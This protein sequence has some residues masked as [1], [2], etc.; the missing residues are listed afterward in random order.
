[1]ECNHEPGAS[2][3]WKMKLTAWNRGQVPR[4][5]RSETSSTFLERSEASE[6][7]QNR[8]A[9]LS[10]SWNE[11]WLNKRPRI[12]TRSWRLMASPY[13]WPGADHRWTKKRRQ[14][15]QWL[16]ALPLQLKTHTSPT[17]PRWIRAP[18][19]MLHYREKDRMSVPFPSEG[20]P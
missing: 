10:P 2:T 8:A 7:H 9:H 11:R 12:L 16:Q 18:R 3:Y 17:I 13:M 14:L 5:R 19:A 15:L 20:W 4:R 1:M 6:W